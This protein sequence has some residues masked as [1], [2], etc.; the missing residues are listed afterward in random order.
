RPHSDSPIIKEPS[1]VEPVNN[2]PCS[3][4]YI[5]VHDLPTKFNSEIIGN[6]SI[7][8]KWS[9]TNMCEAVS[10]MGLGPHVVNSDGVL[11]GNFWFATHMFLLEPIFHGRMKRYKCLTN[12]S[13]V[14]SAVYVPFYPGLDVGRYLWD[15]NKTMKDAAGIEL[16]KW[17]TEKPEWKK[18]NGRDH[19]FVVGRTTWDF[20]R[21]TDD[22]SDWGN[23]LLYLP[24]VKNITVLTIE[25]SPWGYRDF[26]IPHP[27]YF[28]PSSDREVF[29]WQEKVRRQKRSHLFSFVGAPRPKELDTLRSEIIDQC[30]AAGQKCKWLDCRSGV[31]C[32]DPIPIMKVFLSSTFCLQPRGDSY[33]RRSVFDSMVAGCIPV[34]FETATAYDQFIWHLPEDYTKYSVFI[35]KNG[36]K[37]GT[38][39]IE[40]VLSG[41]SEDE[42]VAMR[43][44]VVGLIPKITYANPADTLETVEDAFDLAIKGVLQRVEKIREEMMDLD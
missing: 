37:N 18:M 35:P 24:E 20:R 23:R 15:F 42:M 3:G 36:V 19:F 11:P 9:E 31:K 29:Q 10:H 12:D 2:D 8:I 5:Y 28:H 22:N 21:Q 32:N 1:E 26:A 43:E 4:R 14:A 13:S 39:E 34:F 30:L 41:I 33:T 17:L 25:A 6:C 16:F 7:L 27:T 40:K 38:K 44:T